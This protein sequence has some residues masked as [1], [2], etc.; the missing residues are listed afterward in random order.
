MLSLAKPH[1]IR[2]VQK[3]WTCLGHGVEFLMFNLMLARTASWLGLKSKG[4]Q[5]AMSRELF[6]EI[7][8]NDRIT[9]E[10]ISR[11]IDRK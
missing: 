5:L 11:W 2:S 4:S 7:V 10:A 6:V 9:V 3:N 8:L 1:N